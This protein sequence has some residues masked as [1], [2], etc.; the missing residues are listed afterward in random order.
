MANIS[1]TSPNVENYVVGKGKVYFRPEGATGDVLDYRVGNV[2]EFELS[3]TIETLD[4]FDQQ[5][6]VRSKDKSVVLE[7]GMTAR[8]IMEEWTPSNLSMFLLGTPDDT[9]IDNV[10]IDIFSQNSL[11]GHLRYVGENEIG[12]RW[13]F[14]LPAVEFKP[15]GS[16]NPI[17]DE[18]AG[19]EVT[20]EILRQAGT[21]GTASADFSGNPD[22][23]TEP[24]IS[25]TAK[26]G[27]ELYVSPGG[28]ANSPTSYT[29]KWQI[30]T[31]VEGPYA[32][33]AS[34]TSNKYTPVAG[35]VGKFIQA[36]VTATNSTGSGTALSMPTAAVI[37]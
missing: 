18:W 7:K 26:V 36:E 17:S 2:T 27:T 32:D 5:S 34:A 16:L 9:N 31:V 20:G 35:D 12:P 22:N 10:T 24:A 3:P 21:F 33:I 13:T 19:I 25:G 30:A 11:K 6:G 8:M 29:Y 4:H 15:E 28:W 1:I 14:D 37:A 23:V